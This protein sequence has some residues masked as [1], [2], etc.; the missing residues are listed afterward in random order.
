M[1]LEISSNIY[2][3]NSIT[4]SGVREDRRSRVNN[5]QDKKVWKGKLTPEQYELSRMKGTELTLRNVGNSKSISRRDFLKL[6]AAAGTIMTFTPFVDWGKFL[7]NIES[8]NLSKKQKVELPDGTTANVK[9][10][11]VNS[12]QVIIYPKTDDPLLNKES[13][14]TWQFIRLPR[15]LGGDRN[16]VSAFRVYSAVCLHLWCL[17]KYWPDEGRMR[18]ECPCHG[19][20]YDPLTGEA[21][22]GPASVQGPPSNVLPILYLES[23]SNGDLW[24][25]PPVWSPGKNG[26]VGYGRYLKT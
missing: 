2:H 22:E 13:F 5:R 1:N 20:L 21:F 19:S 8:N 14:R 6:M 10:F 9:T 24:I 11:P 15:E 3:E 16:D 7:P 17:W 4:M 12:S 18:G 23:D 26:I 25:V